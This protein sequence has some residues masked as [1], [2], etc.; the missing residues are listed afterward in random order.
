MK[1]KVLL[2]IM[3]V[4]SMVVLSVSASASS[5]TL[6]FI[7]NGGTDVADAVVSGRYDITYYP[8]MSRMTDLK[9]VDLD[10]DG[11]LDAI[12]SK[13][14]YV[15]DSDI[16]VNYGNGDGTF[17]A[18]TK[19]IDFTYRA[20][21]YE[22]YDFDNDGYLD[23]FI[24][25][26]NGYGASSY[27]LWYPNN[28]DGTFT[29]QNI[30]ITLPANTGADEIAVYDFNN[31]GNVDILVGENNVGNI[32]LKLY[33]HNSEFTWESPITYGTTTGGI[34]AI[35]LEDLN[36]DGVMDAVI[37]W[38]QTGVYTV[39][40][41]DATCTSATITALSTAANVKALAIG[42]LDKDD[43]MDIVIAYNTTNYIEWFEYDGSGYTGHALPADLQY[44]LDVDLVDFDNDN[45]LDIVST[46]VSYSRMI[47]YSNNLDGTF[48]G[49]NIPTFLSNPGPFEIVD[50][51]NDQDLDILSLAYNYGALQ[52]SVNNLLIDS[53]VFSEPTAPTR[54]NY[55]FAGWFADEALT[56]PF[57]FTV[58]YTSDQTAYAKW[59]PSTAAIEYVDYDGTVLQSNDY[60]IGA[61]SS[62]D[63]APT[64][65]TRTGYTFTGWDMTSPSIM[66]EGNVTIQAQ[67]TINQ[68]TVTFFDHDGEIIQTESLDFGSDL[69]SYT[70]PSDPLREG[71]TFDEWDQELPDTLGA[72]N[73][74]INATYTI[75][76]YALTFFDHDGEVI[77]TEL[78]N[79]NAD[80]L[81]YTLPESP[82]RTDWIFDGW[83]IELPN[84]MPA[85][86]VNVTALYI[87]DTEGPVITLEDMDV[88]INV[89]E[90]FTPE[91]CQV[92]DNIDQNVE[93]DIDSNVDNDV[94]GLYT[95]TYTAQDMYGNEATPVVVNVAVVDTTSPSISLEES[96]IMVDVFSDSITYP[97]CTVNDNVDQDL[98]CTYTSLVVLDELGTYQVQVSATDLSG[99]VA[100]TSILT[101][102]VVDREAPV[103]TTEALTMVHGQSIDLT[104]NLEV[105]DN[106]DDEFMLELLDDVSILNP[107]VYDIR[108][109]ATDLSGNTTIETLS[110][111]VTPG[112][113]PV[114]IISGIG[115]LGLLIIA[116]LRRQFKG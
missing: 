38:T 93:C 52:V 79:Y 77:K 70:L 49:S 47:V 74:Q 32:A 104:S 91:V 85:V 88:I 13:D 17:T 71:Y 35:E 22:F 4:F 65:P 11:N 61:D 48:T 68:Y 95:I 89:F 107:G 55:D 90:P 27:V 1:Y 115:F 29:T 59:D 31:D 28:G 8:I 69:S 9:M 34:Y 72:E 62:G 45:D 54:D 80:L 25:V 6:T 109:K 37:S 42:D 82:S 60:L 10:N 83:D 86:D 41:D 43:D 39:V 51:D 50:I 23:I 57:D 46:N 15:G 100:E 103:I 105:S 112:Y 12:S 63:T 76:Q 44:P 24:A 40:M 116:I 26:D 110:L 111:T 81:S 36:D 106:V 20:M 87:Q 14:A 96:S 21:D 102:E 19:L 92:T 97:A 94:L 33:Q 66:P 18:T 30:A 16:Y 7:E 64:D 114:I 56:I 3:F 108:V 84:T 75:N 99:N 2:G 101:V 78:I 67:Y 53:A 73:I 5:F 58:A 113:T 98:E